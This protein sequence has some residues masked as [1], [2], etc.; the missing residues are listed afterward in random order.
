MRRYAAE[1]GYGVPASEEA[2]IWDVFDRQSP[3]MKAGMIERFE[4]VARHDQGVAEE[5]AC[6]FP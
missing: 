5:I 4:R 1:L 6:R 2:R 3:E